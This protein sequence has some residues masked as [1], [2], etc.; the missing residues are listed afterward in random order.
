[1]HPARA[2][3]LARQHAVQLR[4]FAASA[5][6]AAEAVAANN[7]SARPPSARQRAGWILIQVGLWL[8]VPQKLPAYD[9]EG[10]R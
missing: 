2:E 4:S 8:A 10:L 7:P 5:Q 6:T 3:A 9:H 1:M